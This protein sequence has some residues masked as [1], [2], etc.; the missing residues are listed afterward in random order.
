MSKVNIEG[1][2]FKSLNE[3]EEHY[4]EVIRNVDSFRVKVVIESKTDI[5]DFKKAC[6]LHA[7][8]RMDG[9]AEDPDGAAE[10]ARMKQHFSPEV[11]EVL[12]NDRTLSDEFGDKAEFAQKFYR[13]VQELK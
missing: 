4:F 8:Y 11:L 5:R 1:I 10:Y 9:L 7:L 3:A 13:R 12:E 2:E 6:E